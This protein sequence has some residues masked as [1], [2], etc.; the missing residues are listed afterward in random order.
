M[1]GFERRPWSFQMRALSPPCLREYAPGSREAGKVPKDNK[2][3]TASGLQTARWPLLNTRLAPLLPW[4]V[5]AAP[6][7]ALV[8]S[9]AG[10]P[11]GR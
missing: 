8:L 5:V 6:D 3:A 4:P 10:E 2:E 7:G 9:E 11:G 1:A